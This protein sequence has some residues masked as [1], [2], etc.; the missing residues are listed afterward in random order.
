[1]WMVESD[2]QKSIY[3]NL[4]STTTTQL[5]LVCCEGNFGNKALYV[6]NPA[7]A[8]IYLNFKGCGLNTANTS[9]YV[10]IGGTATCPAGSAAFFGNHNVTGLS[11]SYNYLTVEFLASAAVAVSSW[12][13]LSVW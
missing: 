4:V 8:A 1:M 10:G 11:G 12:L 3:A 5:P 6:Y 2:V 7:T 9:Y 13:Q